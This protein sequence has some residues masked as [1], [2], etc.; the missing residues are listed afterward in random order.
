MNIVILDAYTLN[1]G[2]VS[3][4]ALRTLGNLTLYDRT[5]ADQIVARSKDADILFT[6]KTPLSAETL[7]Q[8]KKTKY[9]GVL[10]TGY[11]VVDIETAKECGITVTNVPNYAT[12]SVAQHVFALLLELATHVGHH[13]AEV[14]KGRWSQ[15]TDFTFWDYPLMEL[16]AKTFGVLGYGH[17]GKATARI[18]V[19]FGMR[20]IAYDRGRMGNDG[21][22]EKVSLEDLFAKADILSLHVPLSVDTKNI[23]NAQSI[24]QMKD[25]VILLNTSRGPLIDESALADALRSKKVKAAALD[26]V[27][28]EPIDAN[29]VLLGLPNCILTPHIA[30]APLEARQRLMACVVANL[31]S[32][33]KGQTINQVN[34]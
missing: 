13:N 2:D 14:Q 19:A 27:S 20:V 24:K 21:L 33:L 28:K 17:I 15:S 23:I 5:P 12:E 25:G 18:A 29:H 30:W 6:N 26:V 9:I 1:P 4:D 8:L 10:A 22:V 7:K 32:Y 3:W 16:N 11:N 34:L 31:S